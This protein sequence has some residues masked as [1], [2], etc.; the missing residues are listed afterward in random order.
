MKVYVIC[1]YIILGIAAFSS[2][3]LLDHLVLEIPLT[4]HEDTKTALWRF[5]CGR[6]ETTLQHQCECLEM[7]PSPLSQVFHECSLGTSWLQPHEKPWARVTLLSSSKFLTHR[8]CEIMY[9]CSSKLPSFGG[10]LL[11]GKW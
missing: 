7:D 4:R 9:V 5:P 10:S 2:V 8:N 6:I 3:C 1:Y 11:H